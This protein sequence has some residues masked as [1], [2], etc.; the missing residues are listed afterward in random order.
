MVSSVRRRRLW[1][2][3]G[4]VMFN[5]ILWATD[6]SAASD[7]ALPVLRQLATENDASIVVFH[8][9]ERLFG[10]SAYGY[11]VHVDADETITKI[12]SQA[13]EL[14]D[15]GFDAIEEIAPV[16]SSAGVAHD[17][18]IAA[19]KSG[20]DLIIAATRGHTALGGLLLGSV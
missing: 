16:Q 3:K 8:V 7:Q 11:P 13:H 14:V 15:D 2:R 17:I 9:E 18:A 20:A 5:K 4:A 10:P 19:E 12:R 1:A 6:G